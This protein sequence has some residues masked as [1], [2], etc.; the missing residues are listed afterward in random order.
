[1]FRGPLSFDDRPADCDRRDLRDEVHIRPAK[2]EGL[3]NPKRRAQNDF[4]RVQK[5][6]TRLGPR[7]VGC[8]HVFNDEVTKFV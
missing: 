3:A 5:K 1:M 8:F 6:I 7:P 4:D 2:P